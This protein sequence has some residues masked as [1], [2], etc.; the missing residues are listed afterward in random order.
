MGAAQPRAA[1]QVVATPRGVGRRDREPEL[2]PQ[3]VADPGP[4]VPT[5]PAPSRPGVTLLGLHAGQLVSWEVAILGVALVHRQRLSILIPVAVAAAILIGLTLIRRRGHFLYQWLGLWLRYRTRRRRRRIVGGHDTGS[6]EIAQTLLESV[7]RG[8]EV[9]PVE[10]DEIEVALISHAGG[11]T[12]VLEVSPL[13]AGHV[14]EPSQLLPPLPALLPTA[15]IG[16]PVITAQIIIQSIPAPHFLGLA[17]SA[18]ISYRELAGGVVPATRGCWIALQAEHVAEEYTAKQLQESVIRAVKRLQRRL[19]KSGLRARMLNRDE[20]ATELLSLARVD[21]RH[22]SMTA[23]SRRGKQLAAPA[24]EE[25]WRTWSAGPQV[26]TTF[27]LLDWPDLADPAGRELL[28][29][30]VHT[31]TLATTVTVAARR[32]AAADDVELEA[33]IRVT[34]PGWAAVDPATKQIMAIV[35]AVGGRVERL[36]GEQVFGVAATLPL[37]GFLS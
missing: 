3:P 12:A 5:R 37:G 18:A 25:A 17:D 8:A 6:D 31:P 28:D 14:V 36:D 13:D 24:V 30:L 9:V 20:V 11:L 23:R 21:A 19:K 10:V 35:E 33:A 32:R 16:E 27:R 1:V 29:R 15:E 22:A 26:H 2:E 7:C 34:L 4:P